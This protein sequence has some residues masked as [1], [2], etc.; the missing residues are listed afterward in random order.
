MLVFIS[1]SLLAQVKVTGRVYETNDSL[2]VAATVR[3]KNRRISTYSDREGRY[4]IFA[5]E[6]DTLL[7]SAAGFMPDTVTVQLHMLYVPYDVTMTRKAVLLEGVEISSSYRQDSIDRHN[8]YANVLKKYK[9]ATR[10]ENG[11]GISF[12]PTSIFSKAAKRKREL[13]KRLLKQDKEDY[14]DRSFPQEWVA[15][16][17]RLKGDSLSMFMFRYRPS[18]EFCRSTDQAGMILY[19]NDKLKEFKKPKEEKL[20]GHE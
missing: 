12:S 20:P 11:F 5:D 3:N 9:V 16:L 1:P 14:I 6:G 17:T 19:I 4:S 8:F 7:F 15:H 10:P 18:Y 2:I 13:K